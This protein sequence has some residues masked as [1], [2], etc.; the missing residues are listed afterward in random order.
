MPQ[1]IRNVKPS[2]SHGVSQPSR[3][4][5]DKVADAAIMNIC[6]ASITR[7][8]SRL[9]AMAPATSANNM[10]GNVTEA[11]TSAISWAEAP[12][13]IIIHAA[14]TDWIMPPKLEVTLASHTAR[15]TGTPKGDCGDSGEGC[16][17][18]AA[19]YALDA[20]WP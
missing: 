14:P 5:I 2:S 11:E 9:S 1:P 16:A 15:N 4:K 7:R 8:R 18:I 6:A 17:A 3:A 10:I 19:L 13:A 20:A 12:S